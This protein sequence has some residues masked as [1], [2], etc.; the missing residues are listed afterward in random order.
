MEADRGQL[1]IGFEQLAEVASGIETPTSWRQFNAVELSR[2]KYLLG[3]F[4]RLAQGIPEAQDAGLQNNWE[5]LVEIEASNPDVIDELLTAPATGS[6]LYGTVG[7]LRQQY[8]TATSMNSDI[9]YLGNI[10]AGYA[11]RND[12]DFELN[13]VVCGG[14]LHIPGVGTLKYPDNDTQVQIIRSHDGVRVTTDDTEMVIVSPQQ[15]SEVWQPVHRYISPGLSDKETDIR[16]NILLDDADP[17]HS[18][19]TPH[20]LT[21]AEVELWKRRLDDAWQILKD[22]YPSAARELA[23]GLSCIVPKP[24]RNQFEAYSSSSNISIGSIEASLPAT[25]V[26]AAEILVHEYGGHSKLN[27]I[28]AATKGVIY[29]DAAK[30]SLYAPWRDDPRPSGGLL[31]GVYSFSRVVEFYTRLRPRF[32]DGSTEAN[33]ADFERLL[34]FGQTAKTMSGLQ[35]LWLHKRNEAADNTS[36]VHPMSMNNFRHLPPT[37]PLHEGNLLR[38]PS[39]SERVPRT[40]GQVVLNYIANAYP[41]VGNFEVSE[42][43]PHLLTLA[44]LDHRAL[45]HAYHLQPQPET[46]NE[47][48]DACLAGREPKR[49]KVVLHNFVRPDASACRLDERAILMRH[50]LQNPAEFRRQATDDTELLSK[51]DRALILGDIALARQSYHEILEKDPLHKRAFVGALLSDGRPLHRRRPDLRMPQ[52]LL[53]MQ[54]VIV[55]RNLPQ[56]SIEKLRSCLHFI[57]SQKTLH[58]S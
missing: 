10:V 50:F 5:L 48:V 32:E 56:V 46:I 45:W 15:P 38:W 4:Y 20:E 44:E 1:S 55:D 26:E 18:S 3:D 37:Y 42:G 14:K 22:N 23:M 19:L 52:V 49:S 7:R 28:L 30:A 36:G 21:S 13:A 40:I 39:L 31:H 17:Y 12:M 33:L 43:L 2:R 16:L 8:D 47:L 51:A 35:D 11:W 29:P 24:A 57:M 54:R 9:G 25:G 58:H 27:K 41:G 34:W 6:W 53:A